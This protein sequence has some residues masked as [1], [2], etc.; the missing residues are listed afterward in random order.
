MLVDADIL[1]YAVDE[2]SPSHQQASDWLTAQLDG[3][4]RIGFPWHSL[5]AFIRIS[6]HSHL[7]GPLVLHF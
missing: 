3:A 2:A 1:L 6:T 7:W 4:R 5:V